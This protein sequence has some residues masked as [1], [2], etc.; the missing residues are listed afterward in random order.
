M[1][2]IIGVSEN[3]DDAVKN[4]KKYMNNENIERAW[5]AGLWLSIWIA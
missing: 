5:N 3:K 1:S 4:V 2:L